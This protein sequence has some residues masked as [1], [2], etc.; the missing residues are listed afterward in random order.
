MSRIAFIGL[1]RMGDPMSGFLIDGGHELA[2]FD[3]DDRAVARVVA[4]GATAAGSAGEAA[5]GAEFVITSLPDPPVVEAVY[6]GEDGLVA[7]A[8]PGAVLIDTSTSSPSLARRISQAAAERGA[9]AI[10]APVSGGPMGAEAGTLAVMVGGSD[11]DYEKAVPV[12]ELFGKTIRHMGG[13]GAGQVTKLTNNL[14]AGCYM[15][16]ISEAVAVASREGI[17]PNKLFEVLSNGTGNSRVLHTR[18][19]VPGVLPETPAS[20]DWKPLF[21]VDLAAKDLDLALAVADELGIDLPMTSTA[22]SRY[23]LVQDQ[24]DGGLDYSA[25]ARLL[26]QEAKAS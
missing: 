7:K 19:P 10:D 18:Y 26:G 5:V 23:R 15:A 2:V 3:L 6:L 20:N 13:P 11:V 9:S 25:V 17:D 14:L 22:R 24:G 8:E 21:P 16:S 4:K 1:G 12:L